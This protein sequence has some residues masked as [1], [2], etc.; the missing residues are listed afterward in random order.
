MAR[1]TLSLVIPIFNE[2]P[3]IPEL[4]R[5]LRAFLSDLGASSGQGVGESSRRRNIRLLSFRAII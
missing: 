3:I 4:D 2:E 5:R 1:P